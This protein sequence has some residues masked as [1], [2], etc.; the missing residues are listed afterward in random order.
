MNLPI[1]LHSIAVVAFMAT[2]SGLVSCMVPFAI[3]YT[4]NWIIFLL[5]FISLTCRPNVQIYIE[6]SKNMK[7]QKARESFRNGLP[8][9]VHS[10][11]FRMGLWSASQHCSSCSR[12]RYHAA[13]WLF[14][15]MNAFLGV[16]LFAMYVLKSPEARKVWKKWLF[17]QCNKK[18]NNGH[19]PCQ[20]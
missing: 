1:F 18:G 8:W 16:Y 17:C 3:I 15:I 9:P 5:I 10:I 19:A 7:L 14:T 4:M 6:A 2:P 12:I 20:A 11:W 13:E